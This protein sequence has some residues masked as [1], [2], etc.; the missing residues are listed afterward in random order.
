MARPYKSDV[1]GAR[2]AILICA[3]AWEK[4]IFDHVTGPA[5]LR[6]IVS[7]MMYRHKPVSRAPRKSNTTAAKK[8]QAVALR[9]QFPHASQLEIAV[10]VGLNPGRV[11]EAGHE[12]PEEP[13]GGTLL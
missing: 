12:R 8:Q 7:T 1:V 2:E 5:E 13:R 3:R 4:G 6:K 10:T 11:S 9:K